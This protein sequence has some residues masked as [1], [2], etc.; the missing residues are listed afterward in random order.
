MIRS[1]SRCIALVALVSLC[2][3]AQEPKTTQ[4]IR[5][6]FPGKNWD[7]QVDSPGFKV[8]TDGQKPDG[9]QYLFA[10]N[11]ATGVALSVTLE[12]SKQGADSATCPD[13]LRKRIASLSNLGMRDVEYSQVAS[14]PVVQYFLPTYQGL[15]VR[16]KNVVACSAK[17]DVYIDIHLSKSLFEPSD[18]PLLMDVLNRI[19]VTDRG[20]APPASSASGSSLDHF[21]EG[22]RRY[23]AQDFKGAIE[24]YQKALDL[25]KQHAELTKNYWRVLVD[26]LGMAYGITGDLEKSEAALNYGVSKDPDY[27]MFYY[28]LACVY[29]ERGDTDK[30]M[31]YLGSAFARKQNAIPGEDMPDPRQDDSFHAFMSNERFRKFA[32]SLMAPGN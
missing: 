5:V 1:A 28:N 30:T 20:G 4:N 13:Y 15:P 11:S 29:A 25:E 19:H 27:P 23:V 21:R 7:I 14:M 8:E 3:I 2:A 10:T 12:E 26:N 6:S 17:E 31:S 32:D 9:R 18:E 22:G 16:Q 24:P